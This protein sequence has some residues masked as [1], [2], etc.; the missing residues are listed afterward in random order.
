MAEDPLR[1]EAGRAEHPDREQSATRDDCLRDVNEQLTLAVLRAQEEAEECAQRYHRE[2]GLNAELVKKQ[3]Q[4]RSLASGLTLAEQRER[5]RLA[6][7]LH[8]DLAQMMVLGRLKIGQARQRFVAQG[9]PF[10]RLAADIDHIFAKSLAYTRSLMAELSPPVLYE[11]G[12]PPAL[13]W[14]GEQ[15]Q[16]HGLSVEVRVCLD[17]ISLPDDEAML[18]YQ[19]VRELLL[20]VLKHAATD[21]AT[22]TV[23]LE[24]DQIICVTVRDE[25]QGS[26]RVWD[27]QATGEQFGLLSIRERTEA[28][29]G[30]LRVESAMGHGTTVT[31][32]V[33]ITR[34]SRC[35]SVSAAAGGRSFQPVRAATKGA[36]LPRLL[37]VDDHALVRQGLRAILD[38]Y[39]DLAVVGEAANGVQ[40]VSMAA[41]EAPDVVLMDINMP[42]MDGIEATRRIKAAQP[43]TIV[44]ALSVNNSP[45]VRE[46]VKAGGAAALVSKDTAAD[47]LHGVITALLTQRPD[48]CAHRADQA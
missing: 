25:G 48:R 8:D 20:N 23:S 5:K 34:A 40:A 22:V 10:A 2:A 43:E 39:S 42:Q 16:K 28:M 21:H 18:L 12:L 7:E 24:N 27:D 33:P 6:S 26:S 31:L 15:M 1:Q 37:L 41:E 32:R 13:T 36:G 9:T 38:G 19:S 14:L 44:I 4:L 35:E 30:S 45:Q 47:E 3:Q 46:A 17:R 29:G 11:L